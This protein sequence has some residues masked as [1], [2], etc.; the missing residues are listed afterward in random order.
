MPIKKDKMGDAP[1]TVMGHFVCPF[2]VVNI[3]G[4]K[5]YALFEV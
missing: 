1:H 3:Q 2:G 5:V 4:Y